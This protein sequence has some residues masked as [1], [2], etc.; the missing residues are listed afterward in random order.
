MPNKVVITN[1]QVAFGATKLVQNWLRIYGDGVSHVAVYGVPRGG[2]PV[3]HAVRAAFLK[4]GYSSSI[5]DTPD[6]SNL[7]VDDILDSGATALR[8]QESHPEVQFAVLVMKKGSLLPFPVLSGLQCSPDDWLVFPWE[9]TDLDESPD[10]SAT[11]VV[12]RMLQYIGEDVQRPGLLETPKRVVKAW[13]EW[14]KGYQVDPS[15]LF[16]TFQD[17]AEGVNEMVLLTDIPVFSHCE[18]HIAPFTG[19]AHVAYIPNGRIVGLSKIAR[20]V[21]AFSRRLQVQERLTN[22]IADC[23]MTELKP[24]GA[25]VVI[26]AKHSCMSTRGVKVHNVDTTTSAM[27]GAF[28]DDPAVRAEFLNL[29]SR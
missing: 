27:R 18:H 9:V 4:A 25:A 8:Y 16:K 10:E 17:G 19:I 21:D 5:A 13:G 1:S 20:V 7:I 11:D 3:A 6:Y 29:I 26:K 14:F 12:T 28:M 24:L 22:Q 23:I 15:T 2:V